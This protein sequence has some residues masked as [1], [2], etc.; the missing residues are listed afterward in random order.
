MNLRAASLD[1]AEIL[2]ALHGT[3]FTP[4]WPA[5][6]LADLLGGPGAAGLIVEDDAPQAMILWRAIAGEGEILTLAV[7]PRRRR[8][9]LGRL[10]VEA[11]QAMA[12]DAGAGRLFL[13][14]A[15]DNAAAVALY[16]S[17][18]FAQVGARTA[19]Y[20]RGG[21]QRVDAL[22]M[23]RDLNSAPATPYP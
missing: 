23:R 3:A 5:G 1:D 4:G 21:G 12:R 18:G 15:T 11:A 16:R 17:L 9:G 19:Y 6:L 14:V 8:Q 20:D 22:V 13:E 10:L 2:A 7:D